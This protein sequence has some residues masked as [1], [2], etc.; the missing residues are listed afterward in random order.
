MAT[1]Y[2]RTT[3]CIELFAN[4]ARLL[5]NGPEQHRNKISVKQVENEAAR[6][7]VWAGNLGALRTGHAALDHRLRDSTAMRDAIIKTLDKIEDVLR[8]SCMIVKGDRVPLEDAVDDCS[9]ADEYDD[10]ADSDGSSGA[11]I[12][13][14]LVF[15]LT[16]ITDL[17]SELH[18]L[19]FRIRN[20]GVRATAESTLKARLHR[21]TDL[22]TG[23]D[24]FERHQKEDQ[25]RIKGLVF[26]FHLQSGHQP[27]PEDEYLVDRAGMANAT[28]RRSFAYWKAHAARLARVSRE[29]Q[30]L[31]PTVQS[32]TVSEPHRES[33]ALEMPTPTVAPT[34][35]VSEQR[36]ATS[37]T[38]AT[39]G[40]LGANTFFKISSRISVH[41]RNAQKTQLCMQTASR[42]KSTNA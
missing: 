40:K 14:E 7:K 29:P 25:L 31:T 2:A 12:D 9:D 35:A 15:N 39:K 32:S 10:S 41:T 33:P 24:V 3:T 22:Y 19:S 1:L 27:D 34:N 17:L 36:T 26:D 18:R 42:G 6:L 38:E 13:S 16:E 30:V 21:E 37:A 5:E 4:L 20:P 11:Q 8:T 23:E 28:R